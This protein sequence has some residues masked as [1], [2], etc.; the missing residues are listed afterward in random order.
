MSEEKLDRSTRP[1]HAVLEYTPDGAKKSSIMKVTI[2]VDPNISR[3][4]LRTA[5]T[6]KVLET[7]GHDCERYGTL[8]FV[9]YRVDG[10]EQPLTFWERVCDSWHWF[11]LRGQAITGG[12]CVPIWTR[13]APR[14]A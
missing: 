8:I 11:T 4:E 3:G 14:L 5:L 6:D 7:A 10:S 9:R 1:F 13:L 2:N 12:F